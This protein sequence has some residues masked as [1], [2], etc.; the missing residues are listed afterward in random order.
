MKFDSKLEAN[1]K[2]MSTDSTTAVTGWRPW[3]AWNLNRNPFGE[4]TR[5]ER[6]E[7]AVLLDDLEQQST[8]GDFQA[9]QFIG[10]CGRGK[11]SQ[12]LGLQR[13]WS[14]SAYVY[15]PVDGPC[16]DIPVARPLLIDEFQ[17]VPR[18]IR[19][20]LIR[21]GLPLVLGTHRD[22]SRSLRGAG[23][24]VRTIR[25]G[26]QNTADHLCK[27]LNRRIE[28][29]RLF[30]GPVPKIRRRTAEDLIRRFGSDLRAIE[31]HLYE[32]TQAQ[33]FLPRPTD[34]GQ[35]QFDGDFE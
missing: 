31:N 25:L 4:L 15:M 8:P 33:A 22:M 1:R 18:R 35:M 11:T 9:W 23:Y 30:E 34:H 27:V 3:Q 17:R 24:R 10:K 6:A 19:T 16:P 5:S 13:R 12:M 32:W 26:H 2:Q 14:D 29:C 21:S 7:L 28:H 20:Q